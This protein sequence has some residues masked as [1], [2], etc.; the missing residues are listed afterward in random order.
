MKVELVRIG[1]S[2]G[3]RL[4]K[5]L[6]SLYEIAEGDELELEERQDGILIKPLPKMAAK[7]SFEASYQAMAEE[8]A[9]RAEWG[10]WDGSIRDGL[11]D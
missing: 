3:L 4:P 10:D 5:R 11:D 7:I 6:L 8:A 9:E 1:N 2:K